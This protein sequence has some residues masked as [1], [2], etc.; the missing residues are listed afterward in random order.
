MSSRLAW[1]ILIVAGLCEVVWAV[2]LKGA[3]GF[4]RPWPTFGFAVFMLISVVLLGMSLKSLPLGTAYTIWTGIGAIGT[5]LLGIWLF[6]EAA[7]PRRLACI[8]LI[9]AGIVGL[10]LL[11][12]P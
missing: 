2:C 9:L 7:D 3:K 8:G 6:G 4:T 5:V 1:V 11:T 10:K 12:P